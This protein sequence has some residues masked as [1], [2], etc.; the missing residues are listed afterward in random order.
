MSKLN[1]EQREKTRKVVDGIKVQRGCVDCG[2]A[3]NPRALEFDHVRGE[4]LDA[5]SR[6]VT[7]RSSLDVILAEIAKCEVRCANCH[8]I[9]TWT[10]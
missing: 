10:V 9:R 2:Y 7:K 8:K 5:V 1:A 3:E 4:K 6:L